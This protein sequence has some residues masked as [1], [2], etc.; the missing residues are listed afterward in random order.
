MR[1]V[2]S[3]VEEYEPYENPFMET[4]TKKAKKVRKSVSMARQRHGKSQKDDVKSASL[5]YI[6]FLLIVTSLYAYANIMFLLSGDRF[7]LMNKAWSFLPMAGLSCFVGVLLRPKKQIH[8]LTKLQCFLP[9]VSE[10]FCALGCIRWSTLYSDTELL[11]LNRGDAINKKLQTGAAQNYIIISGLRSILWAIIFCLAR[12]VKKRMSEMPDH[13]LSAFMITRV[14]GKTLAVGLV[15]ASFF[16]FDGLRC[17]LE[18]EDENQRHRTCERTL[19]GEVGIGSMISLLLMAFLMSG[20]VSKKHLEKVVIPI[21]KIVTGDL[22]PREVA[23]ILLTLVV[24]VCSLFLFGYYGT[25]GKFKEEGGDWELYLAITFLASGLGSLVIL[26]VW[27][28]REI[29]VEVKAEE[30]GQGDGSSDSQM[31]RPTHTSTGRKRGSTFYETIPKPSRFWTLS[32]WFCSTAWVTVYIIACLMDKVDEAATLSDSAEGSDVI[33]VLNMMWPIVFLPY[34]M[35]IFIHYD[36]KGDR[37]ATVL[38]WV[39]FLQ[40][41]LVPQ[42]VWY[43]THEE[44]IQNSKTVDLVLRA[45]WAVGGILINLTALWFRQHIAKLG[46][47]SVSEFLVNYVFKAS[48]AIVFPILYVCFQSFNCIIERRTSQCGNMTLISTNLG[49]GLVIAWMLHCVMYVN[50]INRPHMEFKYTWNRIAKMQCDKRQVANFLLFTIASLC[51][52]FIFA[53]LTP[54]T[55]EEVLDEDW[56]KRNNTQI[57][58]VGFWSTL[59][60]VCLFLVYFFELIVAKGVTKSFG[61]KKKKKKKHEAEGAS[62]SDSSDESGEESDSDDDIEA[63]RDRGTSLNA[64]TSFHVHFVEECSWIFIMISF[65]VSVVIT[66]LCIEYATQETFESDASWR[67]AMLISPA[68]TLLFVLSIFM[69]PK[70]RDNMYYYFQLFHFF[71]FAWVSCIAMTIGNFRHGN[72]DLLYGLSNIVLLIV[73]W[74]PGWYTLMLVRKLASKLDG[75]HLSRFLSQII[76]RDGL[77]FFFPII[78]F[79]CQPVACYLSA[80]D[81]KTLGWYTAPTVEAIEK[82]RN[83]QTASFFLSIM[84]ISHMIEKIAMGSVKDAVLYQLGAMTPERVFTLKEL[85]RKQKLQ[86]LL[87]AIAVI[88]FLGLLAAMGVSETPHEVVLS[89]AVTGAGVCSLNCFINLFNLFSA[90]FKVSRRRRSQVE[91]MEKL[92]KKDKKF[93]SFEYDEQLQLGVAS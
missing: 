33:E 87:L 29:Y 41:T 20:L 82:C 63:G 14:F 64:S 22:K 43:V 71:V 6:I 19:F 34:Y 60:N 4:S 24:L 93:N 80:N 68:S 38:L 76:I 36:D 92:Y 67:L 52:M 39:H 13:Q 18:T 49:G 8:I 50:S 89:L 61:K 84:V 21:E 56:E 44:E 23:R 75:F 53:C 51:A 77:K 86:C 1:E 37:R 17:N 46:K 30:D 90:D 88:C 15:Q 25:T 11:S 74:T 35:N 42:I 12:R 27:V 65:F 78:Y 40:F 2:D 47:K 9:P 31:I 91:I 69:K 85:G 48:F 55:P 26:L 83:T 59:A 32:A 45:S 7:Y 73:V 66:A 57:T 5:V 58:S 79:G 3:S 81:G 16:V 62:S 28:F 54:P 70:R 10:V 72:Q